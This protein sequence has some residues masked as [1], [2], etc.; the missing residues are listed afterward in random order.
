[1][2]ASTLQPKSRRER[3]IIERP[4]L[5]KLLDECEA[6]IILLLAPAGYG[7]TT[8]A[9]QWAKTLNRCIWITCTPA[10]RDVAVLAED[11]AS[12]IDSLEGNAGTFVRQFLAAHV[13]PQRVSRRMASALAAQLEAAHGRWLVID[14]FHELVGSREAEQFIE[15]P[16]G[17]HERTLRDCVEQR[18]CWVGSKRIVYGEVVE[19]GR[20]SLA[21]TDQDRLEPL[22]RHSELI[23]K[24]A[25][26]WPAVLALAAAAESA[27]PPIRRPANGLAPVL[28][29]GA[30]SAGLDRSPGT[31]RSSS[32]YFPRL[33]RDPAT[34]T[35]T[36]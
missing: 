6:R 4:R 21:M 18:P 14:D 22:G 15:T 27:S 17:G 24:Q 31:P 30:I 7:K 25:Q 1:M 36:P 5:I 33:R 10:H 9:R 26:G 12:G 20:E 29:G 2:S 3:R 34:R 28:C 23:T 16:S 8:L 35:T 11:L 19:V 13:N 32:P